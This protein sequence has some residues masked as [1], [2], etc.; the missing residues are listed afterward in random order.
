MP[1]S[2]KPTERRRVRLASFSTKARQ[3]LPEPGSARGVDECV[4]GHTTRST[5]ARLPGHIHGKLGDP[6]V[7]LARPIRRGGGEG[8]DS[9]FILDDHDRMNAVEPALDVRSGAGPP[10]I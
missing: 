3:E 8:E 1:T 5:P 7:A 2:R 10:K 6:G 9:V 4:H